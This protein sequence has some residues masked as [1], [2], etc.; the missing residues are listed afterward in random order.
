M[1]TRRVQEAV[2][3]GGQTVMDQQDRLAWNSGRSTPKAAGVSGIIE[4]NSVINTVSASIGGGEFNTLIVQ[5]C[6]RE[7]RYK[8]LNTMKLGC[9]WIARVETKTIKTRDH[10]PSFSSKFYR[11]LR[12]STDI[13]STTRLATYVC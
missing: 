10:D 9:K 5:S 4:N 6:C 8:Y 1:A 3:E 13:G 12:Q 2:F 11:Y 7:Q